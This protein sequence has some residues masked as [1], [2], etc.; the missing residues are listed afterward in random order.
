MVHSIG[1]YRNPKSGIKKRTR[2]VHLWLEFSEMR[3][4][5]SI[6]GQSISFRYFIGEF[7]SEYHDLVPLS[8]IYSTDVQTSC[9]ATVGS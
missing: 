3:T 6:F 5:E 7:L 4:P 9:A 1:Q 2:E 8:H